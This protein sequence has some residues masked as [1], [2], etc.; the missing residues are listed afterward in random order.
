MEAVKKTKMTREE[1]EKLADL[2][3]GVAPRY[4]DNG[5]G[6]ALV[7]LANEPKRERGEVRLPSDDMNRFLGIGE[8]RTSIQ[9]R[10]PFLN[11][12]CLRSE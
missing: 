4:R 3:V 8:A 11:L 6:K 1:A 9:A 7:E 10:T 2:I 12:H 5:L